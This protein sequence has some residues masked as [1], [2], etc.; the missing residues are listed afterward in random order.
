MLS[1]DVP[2]PLD[3]LSLAVRIAL[4][5][6]LLPH[7]SIEDIPIDK[8]YEDRESLID[9]RGAIRHDQKVFQVDDDWV[10]P[11]QRMN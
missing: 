3:A 5:T 4:Q 6:S 9:L 10:S 11:L 2:I 1:T 8:S 7:I